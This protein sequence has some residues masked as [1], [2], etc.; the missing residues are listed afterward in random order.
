MLGGR[1][2]N[3]VLDD[4]WRYDGKK[5]RRVFA[6]GFAGRAAAPLVYDPASEALLLF[7]GY[8]LDDT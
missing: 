3:G 1:N 2:C 6:E 7:G 4:M 5:W 8:G